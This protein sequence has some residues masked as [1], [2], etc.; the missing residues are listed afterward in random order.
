M[1]F[2]DLKVKDV[3]SDDRLKAVIEKYAPGITG[4]PAAKLMGRK[5]CSEILA[6]AVSKKIVSEETGKK[7]ESEITALL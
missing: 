4:N 3:L 2:K 1:T 5:S 6:M 7:I